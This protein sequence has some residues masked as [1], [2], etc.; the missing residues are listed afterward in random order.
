MAFNAG[1]SLLFNH[2]LDLAHIGAYRHSYG[3]ATPIRVCAIEMRCKAGADLDG[4]VFS[5]D[6]KGTIQKSYPFVA[7]DACGKDCE[8][9]RQMYSSAINTA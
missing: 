2:R 3:R 6:V 5:E 9:M 8:T 4:T 7:E 1:P